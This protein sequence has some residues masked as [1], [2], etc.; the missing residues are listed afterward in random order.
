MGSTSQI[1]LDCFRVIG[2][3]CQIQLDRFRVIP[4]TSTDFCNGEYL[5]FTCKV[6]SGD[7]LSNHLKASSFQQPQTVH[8]LQV[9]RGLQES[10]EHT[11]PCSYSFLPLPSITMSPPTSDLL[12]FNSWPLAHSPRDPIPFRV[13]SRRSLEHGTPRS[14]PNIDHG[15]LT[16]APYELE[17]QETPPR[18]AMLTNSGLVKPSVL[19]CWQS[20]HHHLGT[21]FKNSADQGGLLDWKSRCL[22]TCGIA[23]MHTIPSMMTKALRPIKR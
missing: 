6:F 3:T 9:F 11:F 19:G 15:L 1:Q 23:L 17:K 10:K 5:S 22:P 13:L 18:R 7:F 4:L 20:S 12:T 16:S 2:F 8:S 21:Y 14:N